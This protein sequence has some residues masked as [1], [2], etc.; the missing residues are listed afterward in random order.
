MFHRFFNG[1]KC[2]ALFNM[3]DDVSAAEMH[4]L[5]CNIAQVALV[6]LSVVMCLDKTLV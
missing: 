2:I 4:V 3:A 5:G 6:Y 1:E